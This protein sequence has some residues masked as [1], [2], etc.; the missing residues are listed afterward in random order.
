[1]AERK[2]LDLK[3]N[4]PATLELL[5]EEPVVGQSTYG[6]YY[7]YAVKQGNNEEY[8]F[9]APE[10]LHEQLKGLHKGN[11]VEI[12][13]LAEQKGSKIITKYDLKVIS[14]GNGKKVSDSETNTVAR[15]N[16]FDIMLASYLDALR[17]QE[18]LNGMVDVNKIAVCLFIARSKVNANALGG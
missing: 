6:D 3:L 5:F 10:E 15:D 12:T 17:I 7:L 9:F 8:N 1:M 11:K 18:N 16:Y 13:K 2:K 14:N 4:Q